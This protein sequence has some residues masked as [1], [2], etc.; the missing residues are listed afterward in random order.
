M[1]SIYLEEILRNFQTLKNQA[2]QV[3]NQLSTEELHWVPNTESNSITIL[4]KHMSGNMRSRWTNFLSTDGEKPDRF[5]DQEF[6][7]DLSTRNQILDCWEDGWKCLFQALS[8]LSEK[9]LGKTVFIRN[10]PM[11]VISA[12]QR[13]LMHYASHIGQMIYIGKMVKNDAW[14][15]LSIPRGKSEEYK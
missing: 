7:D 10:K 15:T 2:E 11:A 6:I 13:Q 1:S 3:F 8:H 14:N 4:I 5:R 9:D 12:L